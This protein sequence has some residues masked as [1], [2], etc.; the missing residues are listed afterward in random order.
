MRVNSV[1]PGVTKGERVDR[2]WEASAAA[3]GVS[4]EEFA[5]RT[6]N[7]IPLKRA[8]TAEEVANSVVFLAS[9]MASGIT[10][11]CLNVCGGMH[12]G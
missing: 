3:R 8:V 9:D 12:N 4:V 2:V 7:R 11:Q 1:T 5:K 6:V 10:G